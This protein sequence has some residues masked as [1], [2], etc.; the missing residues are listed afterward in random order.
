MPNDSLLDRY[1]GAAERENTRRSY[2]SALRHFEEQWGGFLPA[3]EESIARYLA[4]HAESLALSTLKL[5][6]SA[7][8]RWHRDQGFADPTKTTL[9]R[10]VLKGITELHPARERRALPLPIEELARIDQWL[11]AEAE[12]AEACDEQPALLR[13][14]R[15]R[16]L[17]LLGFWRA[18]RSDELS[19]L[20]VEDVQVFP[21]EGMVLFLSRT[22]TDRQSAGTEFKA[23]ALT[24]LCPVRAYT[25]WI[26][27]AGLTEGPVFRRITR[28]GTIGT[29]ALHASS[30][31]P[32]LRQRLVDAGI[33]TP[34]RYSGH[35]LRRG[36]ATWANSHGWDVK[37]LM[38]YVGWKDATS[39]MR[40]IDRADA[41]GRQRIESALAQPS[42]PAPEPAALALTAVIEVSLQLERYNARVR[43]LPKAQRYIEQSCLGRYGLVKIDTEGRRYRITLQYATPEQL[44]ET[45]YG[46]IDQM[47]GIA[48]DN[49]CF[50]EAA[51]RDAATGKIWD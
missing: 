30:F 22:K 10:Q 39:A 27:R 37:D 41:Y 14:V 13:A 1:L 43:S 20:C 25:D 46:L 40:Y 26:E 6:L 4:E 2:Q 44:D 49:Q 42:L 18:F 47:H 24:R 31:V 51:L 9:V 5:R 34:E 3:T 17:I 48:S 35:S 11:G 12:R 28:H 45:L 32:L 16:A 19:R 50:L 36:F 38:E 23:P 15:D 21:G 29:A 33:P 7:L 8:A